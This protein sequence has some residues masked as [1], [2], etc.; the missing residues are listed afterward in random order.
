[1]FMSS[2]IAG[3]ISCDSKKSGMFFNG[4]NLRKLHYN[5]DYA[6]VSVIG[7]VSK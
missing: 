4:S 3:P 7:P 5:S 6:M 1:M 2:A